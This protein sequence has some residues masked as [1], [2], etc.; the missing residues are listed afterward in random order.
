MNVIIHDNMSLHSYMAMSFAELC[1][2]FESDVLVSR[3][4]TGAL[5]TKTCVTF[6]LRRG[7]IF[8]LPPFFENCFDSVILT[9]NTMSASPQTMSKPA[10]HAEGSPRK[11]TMR[12]MNSPMKKVLLRWIIFPIIHNKIFYT[13]TKESRGINRDSLDE[14]IENSVRYWHR[15]EPP[16]PNLEYA[17][18][19]VTYS[20][21]ALHFEPV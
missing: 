3:G 19:E 9:D 16:E 8:P 18:G 5:S 13:K 12:I 11:A 6:S 4:S 10:F 17:P 15:H 20:L 7:R 1:E 21:E 14:L 2:E